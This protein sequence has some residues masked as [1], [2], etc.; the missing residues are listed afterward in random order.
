MKTTL[1][2]L[3]TTLCILVSPMSAGA[4]DA[5]AAIADVIQ[6]A[7]IQGIHIYGDVDAIRDGFHPSFVMLIRG[8][9]GVRQVAI[10][11]WI[12]RIEA[13][14]EKRAAEPKRKVKGEV[15][16]LD[17]SGDAAVAK[18]DVHRDGK[19]IYTDYMSLY[20]LEDGW[21]IVGKTFQSH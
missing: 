21:K 7:Y 5:D 15:T 8:D 11:D 4:E 12:S 14:K 18:V 19:H 3:L 9:D 1:F 13:G 10:E 20:R 2:A 6:K 17:R 16:V